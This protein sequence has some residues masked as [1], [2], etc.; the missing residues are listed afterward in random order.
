MEKL[1]HFFWFCSG[2][3]IPALQKVPT[4]KVKYFGIGAT[5]FFT[6]LLAAIAGSY[7]LNFIFDD[8]SSA[9]FIAV[10]F[11]LL[12]GL[13][14]FNMDRYLVSS[15]D[16]SA[17]TSMQIL[18]ASPRI[19][20]AIVI[21]LVISRPLELKIFD[22]E[23]KEQ[24]RKDYLKQQH[25]KIAVINGNF[26][27]K[28]HDQLKVLDE[29][30]SEKMR[31]E[32]GI[33]EGRRQLNFEIFGNKTNETSGIMGYG[34]YA[35]RKEQ[36]LKQQEASLAQLKRRIDEQEMILSNYR[37]KEGVLE[38]KLLYGATLN[39]RVNQAGFADRN[40]ALNEL[41]FDEKGQI[42]IANYW[43]ISFIGLLFIFLEC[44]PILVKLMSVKGPYDQLVLDLNEGYVFQSNIDK[45]IGKEVATQLKE[46]IIQTHL[47]AR[48]IS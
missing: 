32:N 40:K 16:K 28:Y 23:I 42:I 24:L 21:G 39:E 11:G 9:V 26:N 45:E 2:V 20:L 48:T 14:I 4:E 3:H 38:E 1:N 13:V 33:K 17:S 12:W 27:Q 7:A 35:K 6:G 31:I 29:L 41:K 34:P 30:K 22:K 5:I 46:K 43:A 25:E 10:L 15:I 18:Q 19:L 47:Q 36:G 37:E 8:N 44:L